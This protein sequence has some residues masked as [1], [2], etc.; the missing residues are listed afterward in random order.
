MSRFNYSSLRTGIRKEAMKPGPVTV[1]RPTA[2]GTL[3]IV[4]ADK[5]E[6]HDPKPLPSHADVNAARFGEGAK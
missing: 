6:V 3:G 5:L 4:P 2:D 1:F